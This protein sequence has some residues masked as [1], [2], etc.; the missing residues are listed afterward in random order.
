MDVIYIQ[1]LDAVTRK[2]KILSNGRL[3][4]NA[5]N[6]AIRQSMKVV[7]NAAIS[8][9]RALNDPSTPKSIYKNIVYRQARLKSKSL[10]MGRIGVLTGWK[11][12]TQSKANIRKGLAGKKYQVG[13]DVFYWRFLELGTEHMAAKPFMRPALQNNI[14][15]V[16]ND[17]AG[18]F[19]AEI[20]KELAKL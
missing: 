19:S 16:T 6:R 12:Y 11:T 10:A 5:A 3:A 4:R 8:N 1:G 17:F 13:G 14:S 18:I 2:L 20:D 15:T 7:L 9:A